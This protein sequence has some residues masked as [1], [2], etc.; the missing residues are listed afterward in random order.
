MLKPYKIR[1]S[2]LVTKYADVIVEAE[3]EEKAIELAQEDN[4]DLEWE[5]C[6]DIDMC[7]AEV[8][9]KDMEMKTFTI[10]TNE[11]C[12]NSYTVDAYDI[13][14]AKEAFENGEGDNCRSHDMIAV[15]I[16]IGRDSPTD[17]PG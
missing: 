5:E 6:D 3:S 17:E 12:W 10:W 13:A 14:G 8:V 7:P 4:D 16:V 2:Y 11:T 1:Q 9:G 15:D